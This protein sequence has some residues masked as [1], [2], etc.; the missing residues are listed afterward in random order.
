[1]TLIKQL[2]KNEKEFEALLVKTKDKKLIGSYRKYKKDLMDTF[3]LIG[4]A[5]QL[6]IRYNNINIKK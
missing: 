2:D 1:M 4:R 5:N 3:A 6:L